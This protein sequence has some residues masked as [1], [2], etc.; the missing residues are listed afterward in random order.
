M[1][2]LFVIIKYI[3]Q[4]LW[5]CFKQGEKASWSFDC[6]RR[7]RIA[8]ELL[9][10]AGI[11]WKRFNA[12]ARCCSLSEYSPENR[13]QVGDSDL[14]QQMDLIETGREKSTY[15]AGKIQESMKLGSNI[16]GRNVF[17]FLRWGSTVSK[18][19]IQRHSGPKYGF[20]IPSIFEAVYRNW[21][22]RLHLR[23]YFSKIILFYEVWS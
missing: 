8:P 12:L 9:R 20:E 17:G 5:E 22:V 7:A 4:H 13:I 16:P 11:G 6:L 19:K 10:I 2:V 14:R 3:C 23:E 15:A 18:P 21:L 1:H